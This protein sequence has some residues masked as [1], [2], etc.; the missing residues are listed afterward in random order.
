[1][2]SSLGDNLQVLYTGCGK[3]RAHSVRLADAIPRV[4]ALV[5]VGSDRANRVPERSTCRLEEPRTP[6]RDG[7]RAAGAHE[8]P[9]LAYGSLHVRYEEDAEDTH[10]CVEAGLWEFQLEYV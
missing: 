3:E 2:G 8:P 7:Q 5:E 1:M 6:S 4:E 10:D 9:Q